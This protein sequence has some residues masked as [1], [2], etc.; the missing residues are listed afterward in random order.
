MGSILRLPSLSDTK[1][2][3]ATMLM[4]SNP[5]SGP[6][7]GPAG[8]EG[9]RDRRNL[10]VRFSPDSGKTWPTS[11]VIE[12]GPS[13]YSDMAVAPNGA[14]FLLYEAGQAEATG[15]FIPGSVTLAKFNW[16]PLV[17]HASGN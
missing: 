10:T 11:R 5:D 6:R 3:E 2:T 16:E 13:G 8:K 14:V 17:Q 12:S 9:S 15:P 1:N 7:S 4:F